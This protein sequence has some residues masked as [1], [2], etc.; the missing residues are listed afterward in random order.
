MGPGHVGL[1]KMVL[2]RFELPFVP[3]GIKYE[4]KRIRRE[5][6]MN[7]GRPIFADSSGNADKFLN[8]IMKEIA[9]LSFL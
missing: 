8:Q 7:F 1:I 5:V 9:R 4:G 3:V 2:S 6:Q